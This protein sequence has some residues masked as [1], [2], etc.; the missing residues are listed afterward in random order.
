MW[1]R[2]FWA[3]WPFETMVL[4]RRPIAYRGQVPEFPTQPPPAEEIIHDEVAVKRLAGYLIQRYA[5]ILTTTEQQGQCD[6]RLALNADDR[7]GTPKNE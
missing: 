3:V 2:P 6:I 5:Q 7:E 4:P 1:H